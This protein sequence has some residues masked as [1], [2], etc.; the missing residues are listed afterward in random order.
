MEEKFQVTIFPLKFIGAVGAAGG[1]G[2]IIAV[3]WVG[4]VIIWIILGFKG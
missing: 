2:G 1:F 3:A 4:L